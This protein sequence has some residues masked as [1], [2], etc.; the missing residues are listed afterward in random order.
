M[1]VINVSKHYGHSIILK[2]INFALNK[3]EI[4]G[5]VGRNGVGKSTLMKILV[6]NNQ[7]TSGNI[8][9]S[10]LFKFFNENSIKV[11][12]FE[13]KKETLKDIYLNRSK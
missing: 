12:D 11:V 13:T 2:D 3:G 5:L 4:V 1:E 10:E 8:Q 7:P 9:S 6:Q